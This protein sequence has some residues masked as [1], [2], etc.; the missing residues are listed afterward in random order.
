MTMRNKAALKMVL[1]LAPLHI[2]KFNAPVQ[3][4]TV[5]PR[6]TVVVEGPGVRAVARGPIRMRA[7]SEFPGGALFLAPLV[8]GTDQDCRAALQGG[9]KTV[10]PGDRSAVL[11]VRAGEMA[12]LATYTRHTFELLWHG[13][14]AAPDFS[15]GLP[16]RIEER[17]GRGQ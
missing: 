9:A 5:R 14:R 8:T 17:R 7:Y 12:C 4:S 11:D 2:S 10:L 16:A 15:L 1:L 3:A 13:L 6:G